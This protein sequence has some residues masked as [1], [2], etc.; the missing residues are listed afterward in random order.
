MA[1]SLVLNPWIFKICKALNDN[2]RLSCD[3]FGN[4]YLKGLVTNQCE[5]T[6][7]RPLL[8]KKKINLKLLTCPFPKI[9][10]YGQVTAIREICKFCCVATEISNLNRVITLRHK[11]KKDI[12]KLFAK[13][14]QK[15][16]DQHKFSAS[17]ASQ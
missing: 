2:H 13:L 4:G 5:E 15:N 9:Y 11:G 16:K 17:L 12:K 1:T 6:A 3:D 10:N 8:D 14:L 7:A